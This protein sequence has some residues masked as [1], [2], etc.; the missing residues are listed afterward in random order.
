[1]PR[2]SITSLVW[3][4]RWQGHYPAGIR[5]HP[6]N[7]GPKHPFKNMNIVYYPW[8]PA[9]APIDSAPM[10]NRCYISKVF[11]CDILDTLPKV[12]IRSV[13]CFRLVEAQTGPF[14]IL[15]YQSFV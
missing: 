4:E 14:L 13:Q 12:S 9:L 1:M 15:V 5:T 10:T 8:N 7:M 11:C 3:M 6:E 2:S